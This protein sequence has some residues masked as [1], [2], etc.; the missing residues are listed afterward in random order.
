MLAL[1]FQPLVARAAPRRAGAERARLRLHRAG[2]AGRVEAEAFVRKIYRQRYGAEVREFAPRL[3][4]LHDDDGSPIAAA[5]Y[6]SAGAGPLFLERYLDAP[7]ERL[8]NGESAP[9]PSRHRVVEVGH[10]AGSVAGAGRRLMALLGAHLAAEGYEWVVGTLTEELRH[11]F[12]RAGVEA[13]VLGRADP[14]RLGAA[15]AGWGS[16]Y[17]HRP[18][19]L[20]GRLEPA[21]HR[22]ARR[23]GVAA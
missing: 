1:S 20:A 18:L 15:A 13:R 14:A 7:V 12:E 3:L 22:L 2:D 19:V 10:L 8:L 21:L 6:R 11:L 23:A 5:G 16:Y 17:E 4:V 9:P